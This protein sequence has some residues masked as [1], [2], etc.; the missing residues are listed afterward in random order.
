MNW[1]SI[2]PL[3]LSFS[4]NSIEASHIF[5]GKCFAV[6]D[7]DT[8]DV[9]RNGNTMRVRLEGIDCPEKDQPFAEQAKAFTSNLISG[10]TVTVIEKE[11]DEYGR[12]VA[13]IF[14][15]GR[16]VSVELLKAGL[17]THYK[18]YNSDWL[19]AALEEEAKANRVGMWASLTAILP[20]E[21]P[22]P[23][24]ARVASGSAGAPGETDQITYHGN[25]NSRVFH[26]PS[27]RNYNCK[28]CTRELRSR[29]EALAAGF[30]PCGICRP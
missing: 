23:I 20:V 25:T 10:K 26:A 19:L 21:K 16:D 2:L 28:N 18:K 1:F 11:K 29:E 17:G 15:D 12:T 13:R 7:G 6:L 14:A 22:V 24:P 4:L 5:V 9:S 8:I 30:R 27:C 3:F